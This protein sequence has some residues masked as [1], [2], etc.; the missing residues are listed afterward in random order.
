MKRTTTKGITEGMDK[1]IVS[2]YQRQ[3]KMPIS[4]DLMKLIIEACRTSLICEERAGDY[5]VSVTLVS[6]K[7]IK[8]INNDTRGINSATDVL[9]FPMS[10]DGCEFDL[11][12]IT[13]C[14]MLGDIVIS[15]ERANE[16]AKD[17]GQPF[18]R[19]IAFLTVHSMLHLMGYDHVNNEEEEL[20][21][22]ERQRVIMSA[23]EKRCDEIGLFLGKREVEND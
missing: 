9:S 4:K 3:R 2:I 13:D 23:L 18:E 16:Q 12:P 19:E 10:E 11:N 8:E 20:L 21:M 15:A 7:A 1:L 17:F 5:E 14:Y 6:N 22:R